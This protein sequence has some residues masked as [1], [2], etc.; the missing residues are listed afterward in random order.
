MGCEEGD[1]EER[2]GARRGRGG[3]TSDSL[4]GRPIGREDHRFAS[5]VELDYSFA[6]QFLYPHRDNRARDGERR[7]RGEGMEGGIRTLNPLILLKLLR[8]ANR[9][10]PPVVGLSVVSFR[11]IVSGVSR[12]CRTVAGVGLGWV[13]QGEARLSWATESRVRSED[14]KPGWVRQ[15]KAGSSAKRGQAE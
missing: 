9:D 2:R 6:R 1:A 13:G 11:F 4:Q 14:R 10:L 8:N 3:R 7:G 12:V 15:R 5:G